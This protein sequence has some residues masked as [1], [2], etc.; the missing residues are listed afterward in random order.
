MN[1]PTSENVDAVIVGAG[2][3]GLHA[4]WKLRDQLGLS[5]RAFEAG[6]GVG[7]TWFWNRYPGA[8]CDVD[9]YGYSFSFD[10]EL[11]QEW[12]WTQ[13]YPPQPEIEA[14]L[15]HVADRYDLRRSIEFE[16]RVTAAT[17]DN[18]T[19]CWTVETDTNTTVQASYLITA[20]GCLSKPK[21]IDIRGAESFKGPTYRTGEWPKEEVDFSGMRVAV[22]GTG[23]SGVQVIPEIAKQA[24]HLTVFQRTANYN[25]P[26]RNRPLAPH[27]HAEW[28]ANYDEYRA[29]SRLSPGGIP[30]PDPEPSALDVS[31]EER[32]AAYQHGWDNGHIP[33][34]LFKYADL[35]SDKDANETAAQFVRD[36]IAEIVDDP[37]TARILTPTDHAYGT[38]RPPL[39]DDFYETF[40]RENVQLV[41]LRKTPVERITPVGVTTTDR[42]YEFDA[43]V[44]ATG[45]DAM[46]GALN[47][48]DIRGSNGTLLRDAWSDG[49]KSYLGISVAG[50]PNMFTITGPGSPSVF[51]NM[52]VSIEQHVD[53]IADCITYIR[54][55][56]ARAIDAT[57]TAQDQWVDHVRE[58]TEPTLH[59][60]AESWYSGANVPGKPRVF[61]P[62]IGG[63]GEYRTRC[64]QIAANNYEGFEL[65]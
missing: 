31:K 1:E 28:K 4:I 52:V 30:V 37:E 56:G 39:G 21:D 47:A 29:A 63:V 49:P 50:F 42:T 16:T 35:L 20:V 33:S 25:V 51:S 60:Q 15:N 17:F 34:I 26:A 54:D 19:A 24:A 62:Y 2:F 23:S 44:Y 18:E 36:R 27:E 6:D 55:Q 57:T 45:F 5:V 40:N 14:Y 11:E 46:I 65:I 43:I 9:S 10:P 41:D 13:R 38:K 59:A 32:D 7:G 8:R 48:I 58:I 53:W 64:D 12:E 61:M 3:A 22:F